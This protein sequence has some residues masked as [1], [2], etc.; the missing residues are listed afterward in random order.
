MTSEKAELDVSKVR[1]PRP[2][3]EPEQGS[4]AGRLTVAAGCVSSMPP[5]QRPSCWRLPSPARPQMAPLG[6]RLLVRPQAAEEKTAG[7]ILL[8]PGSGSKG[9]QDAVIGTGARRGL[10]LG[11]ALALALWNQLVGRHVLLPPL[12]LQVGVATCE[13]RPLMP[14]SLPLASPAASQ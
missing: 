8:T 1:A 12:L 5:N 6:D 13:R 2:L 14:P 3:Q 11:L 7:G 9:M 4:R 10:G